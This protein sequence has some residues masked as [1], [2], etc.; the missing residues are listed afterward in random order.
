MKKGIILLL[1]IMGFQL[2]L[3][4]QSINYSD[5][6][7]LLVR[8]QLQSP[9]NLQEIDDL[10]VDLITRTVHNYADL[11]IYEDDLNKIKQ[12]GFETEVLE[13][14]DKWRI[15]DPE[16]HTYQECLDELEEF[17]NTY[18]EITFSFSM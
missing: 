11:I 1:V 2:Q 3:L 4:S 8:V 9:E 13:S 17:A 15:I 14:S 16:Y 12:L 18:P 6:N 10:Y 5:D 7:Y